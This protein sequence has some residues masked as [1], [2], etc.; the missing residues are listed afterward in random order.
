MRATHAMRGSAT[1]AAWVA[2]GAARAAGGVSEFFDW[3]EGCGYCHGVSPAHTRQSRVIAIVTATLGV[4]S[5][6][7]E[8]DWLLGLAIV[9]IGV[10]AI[11]YGRVVGGT[12]HEPDE[13]SS[14]LSSRAA[15]IAWAVLGAGIV[16]F[17]IAAVIVPG[18]TQ[19]G[20]RRSPVR[21][22]S[23]VNGVVV[24]K[25]AFRCLR[26]RISR[27]MVCER[28]IERLSRCCERP[29]GV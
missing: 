11:W 1:R 13:G 18:L 8:A 28:G 9:G 21:G 14:K 6:I 7:L 25:S 12:G 24:D 4:V 20:R 27:R 3:P 23:Y 15:R 26:Q 2:R 10:G 29:G 19:Q 16:V 5:W 17:G 22:G